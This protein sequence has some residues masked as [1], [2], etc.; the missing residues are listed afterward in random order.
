M[1][2]RAQIDKLGERLRA[3]RVTEADLRALDDDRLTF[4]NAYTFVVTRLV[5]FGLRPTGRPAKSTQA[6]VEKLRRE[7]I[8]LSQVQ[9]VAG[10]RVV[11]SGLQEQDACVPA[12]VSAVPAGSI[13]DRRSM[14]S[15][16]YR[17]VHV[18]STLEGRAVEVQVR[19]KWQHFWAEGSE[20]LADTLGSG[21]KYGV[22]PADVL[23][24][25]QRWSEAIAEWEPLENAHVPVHRRPHFNRV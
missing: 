8:R 4:S 17:A 11:V 20:K 23:Q 5:G 16:G 9:D 14:P 19:T 24:V 25:L 10:C 12:I 21:I 6:I 1:T 13:I 7:S 3:G 18:V 2:S 15:H 22:G